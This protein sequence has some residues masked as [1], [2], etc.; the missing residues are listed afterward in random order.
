MQATVTSKITERS[1]TTLPPAVR[2]A[3][4][5]HPGERLGYVIDGDEVRLVNASATHHEDPAL[6]TFLEFLGLDLQT[7]R[8]VVPIPLDAIGHIRQLVAGVAIDHDAEIVG[9]VGL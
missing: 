6:D 5:L 2:K 3:L 7:H 8:R 4:H 9:D 1:Q